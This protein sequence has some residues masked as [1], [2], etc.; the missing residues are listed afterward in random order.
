MS[1]R[2][3]GDASMSQ[4]RFGEQGACIGVAVLGVPEFI[5]Y[6][7]H[8]LAGKSALLVVPSGKCCQSVAILASNG[9][10]SHYWGHRH[11]IGMVQCL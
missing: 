3:C 7:V 1:G 9:G 8:A 5:R 11:L 4:I 6:S 2:A 10:T